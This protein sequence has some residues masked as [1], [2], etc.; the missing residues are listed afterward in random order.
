MQQNGGAGWRNGT[1]KKKSEKERTGY[2][3]WR[4]KDARN[5]DVRDV[6][7][8][9]AGEKGRKGKR[10]KVGDGNEMN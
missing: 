2:A 4:G 6:R 8:G 9:N 7:G 1:G 3:E 10:E 5:A